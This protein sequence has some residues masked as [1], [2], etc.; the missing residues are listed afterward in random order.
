MKTF[1]TPSS[2]A[3]RV[4]GWSKSPTSTGKVALAGLR[5][6]AR[7]ETLRAANRVMMSS[8]PTLPV[9]P[10]MRIMSWAFQTESLVL[11]RNREMTKAIRAIGT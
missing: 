10:V 1:S 4:S 6:M 2:A 7:M 5:V 8:E 3:A 9:A 11:G